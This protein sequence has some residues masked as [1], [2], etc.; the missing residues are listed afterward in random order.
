MKRLRRDARRAPFSP[1]YEREPK[2]SVDE[3]WR[4]FRQAVEVCEELLC[5][6]ASSAQDDADPEPISG[7]SPEDAAR[8]ELAAYTPVTDGFVLVALERAELHGA[9]LQADDVLE[10]RR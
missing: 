2:E 3:R 6:L 7:V 8:H 9:V 10:L 1:R 5:R 4:R